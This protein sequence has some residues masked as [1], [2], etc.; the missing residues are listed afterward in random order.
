M[1]STKFIFWL[2]W[3]DGG[4]SP[5]YR[6]Q[7]KRDAVHE[8]ERLSRSNPDEVFYVL[9]TVDAVSSTATVKHLKLVADDIPF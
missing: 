9:K 7:S 4:N 5:T 2:V 6:H 1:S 8:A 3:K